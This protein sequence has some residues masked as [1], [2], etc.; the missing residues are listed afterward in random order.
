MAGRNGGA[1]RAA[2][3]ALRIGTAACLFAGVFAGAAR[4][5]DEPDW[6]KRARDP[7]FWS[8][9]EAR[10]PADAAGVTLDHDAQTEVQAIEGRFA[11]V[12][13]ERI[14]I[15]VLRPGAEGAPA[16]WEL[17]ETREKK[18]R[19]LRG[20]IHPAT[21]DSRKLGKTEIEEV[22]PYAGSKLYGDL[23]RK[24]VT[25][26]PLA[27]RSIVVM[28]WTLVHGGGKGSTQ[29]AWGGT[30]SF[31]QARSDVTG[32]PSGGSY[33][34]HMHPFDGLLPAD[35]SSY[36]VVFAPKYGP[37]AQRYMTRG[38][39]PEAKSDRFFSPDG[40]MAR[41]QWEASDRPAIAVEPLMPARS[42][43]VSYVAL[44]PSS[45]RWSDLGRVYYAEY[46]VH[47]T[48]L[49]K[50]TEAKLAALLAGSATPAESFARIVEAIRRDV[51]YVEIPMNENHLSPHGAR[52]TWEAGQ[53]DARD[54]A[55]L[56]VGLL[57]GAGL[58]ADPV[59]LRS[60]GVGP[61]DEGLA[62]IAQFDHV[63]VAARAGDDT[64]WFDPSDPSAR[65]GAPPRR[66][67]GAKGLVLSESSGGLLDLPAGAPAA[68]RLL[69]VVSATLLPDGALEGEVRVEAS[70]SAATEAA[71]RP[72]P[73]VSGWTESRRDDGVVVGEGKFRLDPVAGDGTGPGWNA[74]PFAPALLPAPLPE[75]P[76]VHPIVSAEARVEVDSLTV[77][78]PAGYSWQ[79]G[80]WRRRLISPAGTCALRADYQEGEVACVRE[81]N[82]MRGQW[83]AER[84]DAIRVFLDE[85][86][87]ESG[88]RVALTRDA[89]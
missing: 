85:V 44:S 61:L 88:R 42:E 51:A 19:E 52:E 3:G 53:G 34:L 65:E 5:G 16:R 15:A 13:K 12:T 39:V 74:F 29:N 71:A 31:D 30:G 2:R 14:A 9:L 27:P 60:P 36:R 82:L 10:V 32:G 43:R 21:G 80:S 69:R 81:L 35:R 4:A 62:S 38:S 23:R 64:L 7:E 11:L 25:L 86:R 63:V 49:D 55:L 40:E 24:R 6:K 50:P 1:R 54:Q 47:S 41:V 57:R 75:G 66:F 83:P 37:T 89:P 70:G 67:A 77:R 87:S 26:P 48:V 78:V 72:G 18:V 56:A 79:E 58:G 73:E 76:R 22:A 84:Y 45:Q 8:S 28:E 59:A 68:S 33:L 46:L 20:E 17:P